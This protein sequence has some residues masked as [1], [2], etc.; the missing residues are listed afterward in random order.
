MAI[1][2]PPK[3]ETPGYVLRA[4]KVYEQ[5]CVERGLIT[6]KVKIPAGRRPQ[7][8]HIAKQMRADGE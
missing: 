3:Y 8:I 2:N 7:L 1:N 4:Q 6:V 5:R